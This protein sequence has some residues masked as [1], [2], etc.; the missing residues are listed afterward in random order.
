MPMRAYS[1]AISNDISRAAGFLSTVRREPSARPAPARRT[2]AR[3]GA[4]VT[5]RAVRAA[6]TAEQTLIAS[7]SPP[8]PQTARSSPLASGP[9]KVARASSDPEAALPAVRSAV[10]REISGSSALWTGRVMLTVTAERAAATPTTATGASVTNATP[11]ARKP[12]V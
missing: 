12:R 3:R 1:A 8:A 2:A 4:A 11:T 9:R 5:N 10:V 6:P 7:S